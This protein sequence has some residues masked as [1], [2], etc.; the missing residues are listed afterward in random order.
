MIESTRIRT[1]AEA[2]DIRNIQEP[3]LR[4][5]FDEQL[6][7]VRSIENLGLEQISKAK[8]RFLF[9]LVLLLIGIPLAV[10]SRSIVDPVLR[11]LVPNAYQQAFG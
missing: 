10:F 4:A 8:R 7:R 11:R 5:K 9:G 1:E 3:E 6:E 2:F